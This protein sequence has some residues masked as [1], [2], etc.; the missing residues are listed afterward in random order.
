L[1]LHPESVCRGEKQKTAKITADVVRLIRVAVAGGRAKRAVAREHGISN[2]QVTRIVRR[3]A[4]A[5][6]A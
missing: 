4:W 3:E 1:R 2:M 5:H 6:V